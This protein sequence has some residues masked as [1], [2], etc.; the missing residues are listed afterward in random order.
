MWDMVVRAF[1]ERSGALAAPEP[2][3]CGWVRARV[4]AVECGADR[5]NDE[6]IASY[7]IASYYYVS[8]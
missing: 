5:L 2:V 7:Y 6:Y 3:G 1:R 4:A 8:Y